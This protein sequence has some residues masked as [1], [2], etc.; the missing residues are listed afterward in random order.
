MN[1]SEI[2]EQLTVIF[3]TVFEDPKLDLRDS[4][5]KNDIEM[6]D[7]LTYL[8]M[9]AAVEKQFNFKF[10]LLELGNLE[11]VG[12]ILSAIDSKINS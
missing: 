5:T 1:R 3:R 4:M 12:D 2:K 8:M 7:S 10:K 6:W 11:S 9:I